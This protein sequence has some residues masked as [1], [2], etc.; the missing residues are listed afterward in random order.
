MKSAGVLVSGLLS[1][2]RKLAGDLAIDSLI[3]GSRIIRFGYRCA[4]DHA[5]S[6][7]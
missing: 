6:I 3:L 5:G 4:G 2:C 1:R 7:A